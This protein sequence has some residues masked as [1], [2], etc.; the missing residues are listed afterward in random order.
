MEEWIRQSNGMFSPNILS[1]ISMLCVPDKLRLYLS[2]TSREEAKQKL[3]QYKRLY[4]KFV[5][6]GIVDEE[7]DYCDLIAS[8]VLAGMSNSLAPRLFF[9][10]LATAILSEDPRT[11]LQYFLK[12]WVKK[13]ERLGEREIRGM[14]ISL[15]FGLNPNIADLIRKELAKR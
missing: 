4:A 13:A 6:N 11:T 7:V 5:A 12:D 1:L 15:L 8:E 3:Q 14:L 9:L 2:N 10:E